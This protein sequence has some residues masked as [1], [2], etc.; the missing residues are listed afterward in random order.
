M[1]HDGGLSNRD[2]LRFHWIRLRTWWW[3]VHRAR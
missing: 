2:I 1:R 3:A